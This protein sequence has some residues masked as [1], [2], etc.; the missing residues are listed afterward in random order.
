MDMINKDKPMT[1]H[2]PGYLM[3]LVSPKTYLLK[4]NSRKFRAVLVGTLVIYKTIDIVQYILMDIEG[5]ILN[6]I[7]HF[8]T[9]KQTVLRTK[10]SS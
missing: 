8:N 7:F 10:R 9:L 5:Q 3:Y 4:T 1:Q 2:K 6:C